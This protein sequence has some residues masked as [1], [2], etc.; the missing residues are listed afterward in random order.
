MPC[1]HSRSISRLRKLRGEDEGRAEGGG[2][3]A[4]GAEGGA[5]YCSANMR[6]RRRRRWSKLRLMLSTLA[7]LSSRL[8]VVRLAAG[9]REAAAA[10]PP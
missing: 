8:A 5:A 6:R 2:T 10:P 1:A 7:P 4:A 3:E 9:D